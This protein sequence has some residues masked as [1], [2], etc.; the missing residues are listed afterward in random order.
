MTEVYELIKYDDGSGLLLEFEYDGETLWL[1]TAQIAAL[2]GTSRQNIE[3][4]IQNIYREGEL[5]SETTSKKNLQVVDNRPNLRVAVYNLDVVISVGYR[6][7]S[8]TA[9]KFR[10]WATSVIKERISNDYAALAQE[11]AIRLL[12]RVQVEESTDRLISVARIHHVIDEGSFLRAGDEG[13]YHM[14]RDEVELERDIPQGRLYDYIGSTELGMHVYRLTQTT[15]ALRVDAKKGYRHS[16]GEAEDIHRDIA[17]R[18]RAASHLTHGQYPEELAKSEDIAITT[19][20]RH[21][22]LGKTQAGNVAQGSQLG[23]DI[24]SDQI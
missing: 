17:E 5:I 13:L 6:V 11:E 19:Q 4:H 20:K 14:T 18:T 23:L 1:S 16:Q 15:E 10:Q 3:L 9:T 22:L 21:D 8:S 7:K 24:A 2:F 12:T